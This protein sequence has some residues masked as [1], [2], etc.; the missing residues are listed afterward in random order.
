MDRQAAVLRRLQESQEEIGPLEELHERAEETG[1][2]STTQ[3][4]AD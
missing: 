1:N 4:A 2:K 3:I